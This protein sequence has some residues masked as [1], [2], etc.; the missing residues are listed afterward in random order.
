MNILIGNQE[1]SL[2]FSLT[3]ILTILLPLTLI[4]LITQHIIRLNSKLQVLGF[5]FS[6]K[7]IRFYHL[8]H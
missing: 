8:V 3:F 5:S 7:S 6:F 2:V 4:I 1:D